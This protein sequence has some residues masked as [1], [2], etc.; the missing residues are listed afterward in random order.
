MVNKIKK[1]AIDTS[2]MILEQGM[3][4]D[5]AAGSMSSARDK[6]KDGRQQL[7]EANT[8]QQDTN[9]K[10][11]AFCCLTVLIVAVIV[12]ILYSSRKSAPQ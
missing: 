4:L 5:L 1:I 9:R 6:L 10:M 2:R 12:L 7:A 11:M 8:Y 3:K